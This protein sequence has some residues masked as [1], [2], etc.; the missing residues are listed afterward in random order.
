MANK[1]DYAADDIPLVKQLNTLNELRNLAD[2]V[3]RLRAEVCSL[4][5]QLK[6]VKADSMSISGLQNTINQM[7]KMAN[8]VK[9]KTETTNVIS[10]PLFHDVSGDPLWFTH[11]CND[12]QNAELIRAQVIEK[13]Q[14]FGKGD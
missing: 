11:V 10:I 5:K 12:S 13:L 1:K 8:K 3:D 7:N 4:K 6:K 2:Y 14:F 9:M